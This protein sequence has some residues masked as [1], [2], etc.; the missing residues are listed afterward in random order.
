[1]IV[2]EKL[3]NPIFHQF[4]FKTSFKKGND[5]KCPIRAPVNKFK[6]EILF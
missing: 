5:N 1:M 6:E 2:Y 4:F 3:F